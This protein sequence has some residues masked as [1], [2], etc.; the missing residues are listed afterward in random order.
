M[1]PLKKFTLLRLLQ[2]LSDLKSTIFIFANFN[3][4]ICKISFPLT[5]QILVVKIGEK[6]KFKNY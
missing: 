5:I 3:E 1:L 6:I 4:K 2:F